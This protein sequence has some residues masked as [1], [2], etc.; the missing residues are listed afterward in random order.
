ML[1]VWP[2][3]LLSWGV[4]LV[5]TPVPQTTKTR[6][7]FLNNQDKIHLPLKLKLSKN[8]LPS[9]NKI[10][11]FNLN[12]KDYLLSNNSKLFLNLNLTPIILP[13]LHTTQPHHILMRYLI[14]TPLQAL[15]LHLLSTGNTD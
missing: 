12:L 14:R 8:F 6:V 15:R 10:N 5:S 3:T 4:P 1:S 13:L 11:Y 2:Q 9:F 7:G